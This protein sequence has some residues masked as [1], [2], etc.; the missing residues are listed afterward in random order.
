[1][2][3]PE[4]KSESMDAELFRNPPA[5]YRGIPFWSWNC[6]VTEALIDEQLDIFQEMGFVGVDIH[7]RTGLDTVYLSDEY[8]ALIRYAVRRCKEK[9]L[10]CWLYDDDRFP[11]GAA[12]GLV[13]KEIRFRQRCLLLTE[14]FRP[15]FLPDH[16]AFDRAVEQ[17]ETPKGWYAASYAIGPQSARRLK[18]DES[19]QQGETLRHAYVMLLEPEDWFQGQTYVDVMNPAATRQFINITHEAY[20]REVGQDFGTAVPAIFTDEP[21]MET[22]TNRHP[23]QLKSADS[24]EDVIIPWSDALW[25]RLHKEQGIDLLDIAPALIWELPESPQARY[26]FRNAASEQ[27]VSAFLD[28]IASWCKDHRILMTGHVLSE[29]TL[30]AQAASLGDCMRCYRSMDIPGVDVLCDNRPFLAVKQ[31]ASVAHQY[32]RAGVASELY[33]VTEWNCDFK[34]FKLQGDWQTALGI[35][36]RVPHL[37]WMSMAGEAKRDWPGS[38]FYQAPWWKEFHTVED[39]FARL[40]TILSRGKPMIDIAVIHPVESMWL[41]L[42]SNADTLKKRQEMD[43]RFD[44]LVQGLLMNLLDFDLVSEALLPSQNPLADVAGLHIGEM[45]YHTILVP[46]MDTIRGS[47]LDILERFKQAGGRVIFT[48]FLPRLVDAVPSERAVKLAAACEKAEGNEALY[49]L[50]EHEAAVRISQTNGCRTDS[51]LMQRRKEAD[52]EWIFLCHA[53]PRNNRISMAEQYTIRIQGA[54]A[55]TCYD[56][57]TGNTH[58][59]FTVQQGGD[60]VLSWSAYAED[61]LL[62]RLDKAVE[63]SVRQDAPALPVY[64]SVQTLM[65]PDSVLLSEPNMLLLDYAQVRVD[66]GQISQKTEILRLDNEIRKRLGFKQRYGSMMQPYAIQEKETRR[67]TLYYEIFS[68]IEVACILG[69][70]HPE[71]CVLSFNDQRI[72]IVDQGWYVDQSIRKIALPGLQ[73]G[74]NHLKIDMP[75]NQKTNLE[76]LYLLGD[77]DVQKRPAGKSVIVSRF[78]EKTIGDL[79]CQGLPFYSGV[80]TYTFSFDADERGEYAIHI[81][82]FAASLLTVRLDRKRKGQIAY[83]PHRLELGELTPGSHRLE[84]DA[85]IGRHNGFGYLHNS[86]S[87]FRWFGPDAWRTTGDEWTD[88]YRILPG[89]ILSEIMIEK[90]S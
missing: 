79:S 47:T 28:Q 5:S 80:V 89:G 19:I 44:A 1:M 2:L 27:F 6:K 13:T 40:N 37:S 64:H 53:W 73:K 45:T 18:N 76:N 49:R 11:S 65:F 39:Y 66:D 88:D 48:G 30:S 68:E 70:E 62:L 41:H 84:I 22:R 10:L 4:R 81:P 17:D 16:P 54:H 71:N 35:T 58:P 56:P 67:I 9:G 15:D 32:G 86:N 46:D 75:F 59:L 85:F 36:H 83:E 90:K 82:L 25:E 78:Y 33:G 34:T 61:S 63:L 20:Y 55:V 51:L 12:D 60:T 69:M 42:G 26:H 72:S 31:A 21:R 24:H 50:L 29:D 7:P 3:N 38:I 8:M 87:Q 77:F 57:L 23:K 14:Q 74:I 43:S 52:V